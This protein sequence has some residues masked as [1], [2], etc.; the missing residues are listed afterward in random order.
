APLAYKDVVNVVNT[1]HDSNISTKV[2]KLLP[3]GVI[4][5]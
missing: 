5:G 4:K 3:I 1:V 2:V